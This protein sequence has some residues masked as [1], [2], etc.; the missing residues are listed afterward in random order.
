MTFDIHSQFCWS[1][2]LC[3][4]YVVCILV[5]ISSVKNTR[6]FRV[7]DELTFFLY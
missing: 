1:V 7:R 5:T 6:F 4:W 2:V 3:V